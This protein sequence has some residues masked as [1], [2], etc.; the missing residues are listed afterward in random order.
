MGRIISKT[1][2]VG[3]GYEST[4]IW[5]YRLEANGPVTIETDVKGQVKICFHG[6]GRQIVQYR[7][8]SDQWHEITTQRY[9]ALGEQQQGSGR[10]WLLAN[11]GQSAQAASLK[12]ACEMDYDGWGLQRASRFS[13]GY[14]QHQ[15]NNPVEL[16]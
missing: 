8:E 5:L 7:Y 13:D 6:T 3:S 9:N 11:N 4:T 1:H 15:E 16:N 10:D 14:Q 2:A 12:I